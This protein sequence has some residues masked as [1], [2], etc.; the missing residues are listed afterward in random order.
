MADKEKELTTT[1]Y[2]SRKL[3]DNNYGNGE[4]FIGLSDIK[5]STTPDEMDEMLEQANLAFGKLRDKLKEKLGV[6]MQI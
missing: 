5:A 2:I 3:G 4:V 1:V 6:V